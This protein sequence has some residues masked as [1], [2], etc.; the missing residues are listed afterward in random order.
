MPPKETRAEDGEEESSGAESS[1]ENEDEESDDEEDSASSGED[2]AE[3]TDAESSSE[4]DDDAEESSGSEEDGTDEDGAESEA[5]EGKPDVAHL[6]AAAAAGNSLALVGNTADSTAS[7]HPDPESSDNSSDLSD[8]SRRIKQK[9]RAARAAGKDDDD[10]VEMELAKDKKDLAIGLDPNLKAA[11]AETLANARGAK[12][13]E[14]QKS[15]EEMFG[16]VFDTL[17]ADKGGT[18]DVD[19]ELLQTMQ[20]LGLEVLLKDLRIAMERV[21]QR[22]H[23]RVERVGMFQKRLV[24]DYMFKEEFIKVMVLMSEPEEIDKQK[25]AE[26]EL[27]KVFQE[28]DV[29]RSGSIDSE[30]L[31]QAMAKMG[32]PMTED[33][34]ENLLMQIDTEGTGA[35]NFVDFASIFGIRA[36]PV[37]YEAAERA[38]TLNQLAEAR[39]TFKTFDFDNSDSIDMHELDAIM[40]AMGKKMSEAQLQRMMA[41]VDT[42]GSGEIDFKEFCQLLGVPWDDQAGVDLKEIDA[43]SKANRPKD[44]K[45]KS[46]V[47]QEEGVQMVVQPIDENAPYGLTVH[48]GPAGFKFVRFSP[49]GHFLGICC[50]D[51]SVKVYEMKANGKSRRMCSMR[52]HTHHVL[53]LAWSPQSDRLVS[54]AADR[55]LHMWHVKTGAC[56]QS[57]K[58]HSA[59]VRCV[60][61]SRDGTMIATCS[62]DKTVKLFNPIT[63]EQSKLLLGHSNWVRFVKFRADSKRLVSGGDDN[64]IIIWSV[65]EGQI[66]QR[67]SGFKSSIAD[68]CFLNMEQSNSQKSAI[69]CP[70]DLSAS[71]A[72][73]L[74]SV[75]TPGMWQLPSATLGDWLF[76]W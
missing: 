58:A 60:D 1:N 75:L 24:W 61:W 41:S 33:Q 73:S 7:K 49:N 5:S 28:F 15:M 29:D 52:E 67:M 38:E 50:N 66:V 6:A 22:K 13:A 46:S 48:T 44:Q 20:K 45:K 35:I 69:V 47:H 76:E 39:A 53:C 51:G 11:L 36:T 54:V 17:D 63:L 43:F 25:Q 62:S 37:D 27:F 26:E 23:Q 59:Y 42:D 19:G 72:C 64:F 2:D 12:Q 34:V 40:R 9:K 21:V 74:M 4:G 14:K 31:G 55:M 68:V 8:Q 16:S 57:A 18:L 10:F 30:E 71:A 32:R 56:V 65:P 3:E 70:C